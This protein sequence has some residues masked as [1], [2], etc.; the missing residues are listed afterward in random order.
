MR[1]SRQGSWRTPRRRWIGE[2]V[3]W[4]NQYHQRLQSEGRFEEMPSEIEQKMADL[5][6]A[7]AFTPSRPEVRVLYRPPQ[8]SASFTWNNESVGW[9]Q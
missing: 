5:R 8:F 3:G 6:E 9:N 1:G 4:F 2:S 7:L